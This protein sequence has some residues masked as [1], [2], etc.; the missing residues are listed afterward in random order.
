MSITVDHYNTISTREEEETGQYQS[1]GKDVF[2]LGSTK[3]LP[4]KPEISRLDIN[5]T[6]PISLIHVLADEKDHST[7]S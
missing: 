4:P 7:S 5:K 6:E 1:P 2:I 3:T